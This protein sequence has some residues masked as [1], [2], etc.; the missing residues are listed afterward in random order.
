MNMFENILMRMF[1]RPRGALG[2][3]GGMIMARMNQQ[4]AAWVIDLLEV[5]P[6]DRILEVGFGPGVGIEL[7]AKSA[8]EGYVAGVDASKEMV[9]QAR[10]RNVQAITSG[11]VDLQYGFAESLPFEDNTFNKTLAV[12]S[13]QVWTDVAAGLREIRRVMQAG[14]RIALGFTPYSGQRQGGLTERLTAAGLTEAHVVET[15][16]GFCVLASKP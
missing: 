4:C 10:A 6:N 9:D 2:R 8:P 14:G 16:M 1:G 13:M 12:N 15:D 5:Q 11:H 3:L 7:L